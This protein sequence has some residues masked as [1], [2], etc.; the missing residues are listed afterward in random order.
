MRVYDS[1]FTFVNSHLAADQNMVLRRNQDYTYISKKLAFP[2]PSTCK[3]ALDYYHANPW[4]PKLSDC[5][6]NINPVEYE[7]SKTLSMFDSE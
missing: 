3:T 6:M 1:Y 5:E 7:E 4:V 2:L